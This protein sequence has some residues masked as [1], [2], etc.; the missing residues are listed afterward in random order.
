MNKALTSVA[1]LLT[2]LVVA[3]PARVSMAQS[4]KVRD[5]ALERAFLQA[6]EVNKATANNN[7]AAYYEYALI[8]LNGDNLSDAIVYLS[9]GAFCGGSGGCSVAIFQRTQNGYR[10]VGFYTF[11]I[12]PFGVLSVNSNGWRDIVVTHY[13]PSIRKISY[14]IYQFDGTR[15][16]KQNLGVPTAHPSKSSHRVFF[17]NQKQNNRWCF[18]GC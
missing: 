8:D 10:E 2:S 12:R 7:V 17:D 14:Q 18:K 1:F 9:G 13:S 16:P 11:A 5:R 15:Y 6:Q 4:E 3:Y